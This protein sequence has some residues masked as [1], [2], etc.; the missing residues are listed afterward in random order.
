MGN[1]RACGSLI[2]VLLLACGCARFAPAP[3]TL[4]GSSW[5][6]VK[7]QGGDG[8]TRVPDDK[9][10]YTLAF[11]VDGTFN[12]RFDCNRGR[13]GWKSPGPKQVRFGAMAMTRAACPPGSMH[14]QLV[15]HWS[16]VRAYVIEGGNLRLSLMADGGIYEFEPAR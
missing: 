14:D 9:S 6:L 16:Y 13:G 1:M 11:G 4:A 15:K 7:F 2:T 12:V 10:K 8:A 5:Q 3:D